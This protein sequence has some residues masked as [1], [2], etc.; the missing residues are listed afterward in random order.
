MNVVSSRPGGFYRHGYHLGARPG[1]FHDH[2][3]GQFDPSGTIIGDVQWGA[4]DPTPPP[5]YNDPNI[6]YGTGSGAP[7]YAPAP[8]V[9]VPRPPSTLPGF[10]FPAN[11]V[12][13]LYPPGTLPPGPSPRVNVPLA[14]TSVGMWLSNKT[15]LSGVP[16]WLV[17][18]GGVLAIP[19]IGGL[20]EG[21]RRRR[22]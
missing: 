10:T 13:A 6:T 3:L 19:L 20:L 22:R 5:D 15:I 12:S 1:G 9:G 4:Q 18:G 11:T 7:D 17:L 21:G 16:N 14:P 2:N 8:S